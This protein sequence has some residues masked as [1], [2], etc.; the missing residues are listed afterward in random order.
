MNDQ[1]FTTRVSA[2]KLGYGHLKALALEAW[3]E[4]S[5]PSVDYPASHSDLTVGYRPRKLGW[6]HVE[7]VPPGQHLTA[8]TAKE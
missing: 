3:G 8:H 7:P 1:T 6:S 2:K 4:S 5:T